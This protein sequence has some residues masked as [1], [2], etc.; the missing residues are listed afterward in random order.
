[1]ARGKTLLAK[2]DY[3]RA[4]LEFKNA[5][6]AMPKD[7]EPYYQAGLAALG[8][9]DPRSAFAYFNKAVQLNPKH[10]DAQLKIAELMTSSRNKGL[11]QEA[12]KRLTEMLPTSSA[13]S[14]VELLDTL[15]MAEA[16]LGKS[17]DAIQHLQQALEKAPTHLTTSIALAQMKLRQKDVAG[18]EEIM[19]HA[20]QQDPKSAPAALALAQFYLR[21]N[22]IDDGL[23]QVRRALEIDPKNGPALFTL[24]A[25]QFQTGRKDDAEQTYARLSALPDK[26]YKPLHATFLFKTGKTDAAIVEFEKLAKADSEDRTARSRLVAAYVAAG[27]PDQAQRVLSDALQHNAKDVDALLERSQLNLRA[28]NTAGAEADLRQVLHFRPDSADAHLALAQVY[29]TTQ[30]SLLRRQELNEALRLNPRLMRAR[31]ELVEVLLREKNTATALEVISQ[32]PADQKNLLPME[33]S[34]IWTKW[35]SG[36]EAGA[37]KELDRTLAIARAPDLVF[38][39]A[40]MKITHKDYAGAQ[41]GAEEVLRQ[42]P[43]DIRAL[44]LLLDACTAQKKDAEGE[45]RLRE[46]AVQQPKSAPIQQLLGEWL[47]KHGKQDEARAAFLAAKSANAKLPGPYISLAMLDLAQ[48]KAD[49]ARQ[50][51]VALLATDSKNLTARMLLADLEMKAGN[52]SGAI[53]HLRAIADADSKNALALNNLAYLL[54]KTDPDGALKYAQQADEIAPQN[55]A[56]EDTLGWV[57]YRKGLYSNALTHL[58]LAVAKDGTPRRQFHLGMAYVKAGDQAT[59]RQIVAAALK[60]DPALATSER[61]W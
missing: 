56:I 23:A 22:R 45:R 30:S 39:D 24:A 25:I 48:N 15:A 2:Q 7:A 27:K 58:K 29:A 5:T 12:E 19:K 9:G 53:E 33:V 20:V 41:A 3:S 26:Q 61:D 57:Y 44:R 17:E 46:A 38:Q 21:T 10:S 13:S 50:N 11:V 4:L 49:A 55:A 40:A 52:T 60:S 47:V 32:T 54:A 18:A 6:Q 31:T 34:L 1:M 51:L 36:D 14:N 43:Q 28:G 37:R 8:Q 42:S 59:G 35:L 16:Q